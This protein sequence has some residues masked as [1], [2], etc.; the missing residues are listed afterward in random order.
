MDNANDAGRTLRI[1]H[2]EDS[3]RDAELIR[4]LLSD[5]GFAFQ[6]DL[7]ATEQEFTNF[8]QAGGYDLILA[9]Y[10]LVNFDAPSALLQTK[11]LCPDVPFICISG[12][13]GE[14]RAV[15]LLKLGA[16]DY[17]M[18][19]RIKK[20]PIAIQR[21][22][23]E[24]REHNARM[25]VETALRDAEWK[26]VA[27]FD[28]G[29]IAV[30]YNEMICDA[31]GN[32]ID[33]R[34][35][36]ANNSFREMIGVDPRG[37]TIR[38]AVPDIENETFD[39]FRTYGDVA[40]TGQDVRFE[41]HLRLNDRWYDCIAFQYE[42]D[43]FVTA[44]LD[45]TERKQIEEALWV[46]QHHLQ[47]AQQSAGVGTWNWD[48]TNQQLEWSSELYTLFGLDTDSVE[49]T[50]DVWNQVLHPDD[51]EMAYQRLE[52]A[53]KNRIAFDSEYRVI[54][55][56]GKVRWIKA[57]GDTQYDPSGAPVRMAGICLDIT[58]QKQ[59]EEAQAKVAERDHHIAQVLQKTL[60]PPQRPMQ[61]E[62]Y[63]IASR[64]Q[65]VL[66]EAEVC[67]DFYDLIDL[68]DGKIGIVIG[69]VVGKGLQAAARVAAVKHT[70]RSYAY[71]DDRPSSVLTC[72]NSAMYR[73]IVS[74]NDMLTVFLAVLDTRNGTLT[75]TNA[76]HE[77]PVIGHADGSVDYLNVGG[78]MFTGLGEQ[79]YPEGSAIL[80]AGDVLVM[81]T[82]GI[83][84]ARKVG[85][86]ELFG[87]EG[88]A[89]CLSENEGASADQFTTSLLEAAVAYADGALRDDAAI[90]V[91]KRAV[92]SV[93]CGGHSLDVMVPE[94][95]GEPAGVNTGI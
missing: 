91:V 47:F 49:A 89:R 56:E 76:G 3:P 36:D 5:A 30:A 46:S 79:V 33:Y 88:I 29:P 43:H 4:E 66:S 9:D 27:L 6:M 24:V 95:I 31:S 21:A 37:K 23:D 50:F 34:V 45:I 84:E 1:L 7:A 78:P 87:A 8:M 38:E 19:D 51:R 63:E 58:E 62:G 83:T 26:F 55:P 81:V 14:E 68:G 15:E 53:M 73:D 40:R 17:V 54:H 35:I 41:Q 12:V 60:M 59:I 25:E 80:R 72:V 82:D 90:V 44:F 86:W 77:P 69:D 10:H 16:T 28:K 11:A 18:K 57:L 75:Y 67:G 22:L 13:I 93:E 61:P 48:I 52:Q 74:E 32:P 65:P 85:D 64:Y 2:V 42:P 39:W 94:S 20:L 92:A 71:V 70:I